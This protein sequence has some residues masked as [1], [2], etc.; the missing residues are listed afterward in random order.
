MCEQ[1]AEKG[2]WNPHSLYLRG[3]KRLGLFSAI[4]Y[5]LLDVYLFAW[6]RRFGEDS[7]CW[8]RNYKHKYSAMGGL[9]WT[10]VFIN[11]HVLHTNDI[12]CQ[13][14][15][16]TKAIDCITANYISIAASHW[17]KQLR[18]PWI[19]Q[20]TSYAIKSA[21]SIWQQKC[22]FPTIILPVH[23]SYFSNIIQSEKTI[24]L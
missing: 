18:S 11:I 5:L 23:I 20:E 10:L 16:E 19:W 21:Y 14:S 4:R 13:E 22:C 24:I 7:I 3:V 1:I 6:N 17:T 9:C 15:Q 8:C 12:A 2:C